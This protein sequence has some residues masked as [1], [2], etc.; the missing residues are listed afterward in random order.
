MLSYLKLAK[1]SKCSIRPI[2]ARPYGSGAR[3]LPSRDLVRVRGRLPPRDRHPQNRFVGGG[4]RRRR[5][6]SGRQTAEK[7]MNR[8]RGRFPVSLR[9]RTCACRQALSRWASQQ[10]I[11]APLR[12]D[13]GWVEKLS[14][15][16]NRGRPLG[17]R[18]LFYSVIWYGKSGSNSS[19]GQ[20]GTTPRLGRVL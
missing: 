2:I 12:N 9:G 14:R 3:S 7:T 13:R 5:A 1:A 18:C 15:D 20:L 17:K 11:G 4:R 6:I 19:D 16:V 8:D 10:S